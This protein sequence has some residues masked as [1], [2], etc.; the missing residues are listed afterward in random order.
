MRDSCVCDT[1]ASWLCCS[2]S[3]WQTSCVTSTDIWHVRIWTLPCCVTSPQRF[4]WLPSGFLNHETDG[5]CG[6]TS[7]PL[8]LSKYFALATVSWPAVGSAVKHRSQSHS[9]S[10]YTGLMVLDFTMSTEQTKLTQTPLLKIWVPWMNCNLNRRRGC[11]FQKTSVSAWIEDN[12]PYC[13]VPLL[14]LPLVN[15]W[16]WSSH[17]HQ[18]ASLFVSF[19]R[20]W[21]LLLLHQC[22]PSCQGVQV[23]KAAVW[24]A[25]TGWQPDW[26]KQVW[27]G[28]LFSVWHGPLSILLTRHT[29]F[30]IEQPGGWHSPCPCIDTHTGHAGPSGGTAAVVGQQSWLVSGL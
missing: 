9:S 18:C 15:R 30:I 29:L 11:K 12:N 8:L 14:T 5:E 2:S 17:W 16:S 25:S 19:W 3:S 4:W 20:C 28:S 23:R 27:A 22:A 10:S 1:C 6:H 7:F 24:E 21:I 26:I 13:A